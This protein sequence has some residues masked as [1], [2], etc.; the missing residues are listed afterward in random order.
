MTKLADSLA[1]PPRVMRAE[2]AAAYVGMSRSMFLK[3]V[4]DGV[5]P[6]ATKIRNMATWDRFDLDAA[7]DDLKNSDGPSENTVHKQLRE[8][9]AQRRRKG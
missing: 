4:D 6:K 1:Y 8:L 7:F 3:L 9:D 5:M 2:T